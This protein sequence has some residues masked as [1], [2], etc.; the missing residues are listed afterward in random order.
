[1]TRSDPWQTAEVAG[2]KKAV[3]LSKPEVFFSIVTR[4]SRQVIVSG[5]LAGKVPEGDEKLADWLIGLS[6]NTGIP[7]VAT[8]QG[9]SS[10]LSRDFRPVAVFPAVEVARRLSDPGWTGF[11][12]NGPYDLALFAGIPYQMTWTILSGLKH[13]APHLRTCVVDNKYQ[14]QADWSLPNIPDNEW[15]EFFRKCIALMAGRDLHV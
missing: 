13:F 8:A 15:R 1:M 5:H 10:F 2:P 3:L 4:A 9:G 7:L 6:R 12:G 11:D 14:P